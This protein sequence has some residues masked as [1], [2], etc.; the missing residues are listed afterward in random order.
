MCYLAFMA[1]HEPPATTSFRP[2]AA[3]RRLLEELKEE[4]DAAQADIIR[5]GLVALLR[6]PELRRELRAD[7]AVASLLARLR[8]SYGPHAQLQVPLS[9]G[10]GPVAAG[11]LVPRRQ[12]PVFDVDPHELDVRVRHD[13]TTYFVDLVDPET[14]AGIEN[15]WWKTTAAKTL[16]VFPLAAVNF[17]PTAPL[18]DPEPVTLPDGRSA[19]RIDDDGVPRYYVVGPD[20]THALLHD[21]QRAKWF[22]ESEAS[23]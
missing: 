5:L 9:P 4:L 2:T 6:N 21:E 3:D 18:G 16:A 17:W 8:D 13:G 12:P 20:G 1:R 23:K 10:E 7:R 11:W 19:V 15:A 14:G 22:W